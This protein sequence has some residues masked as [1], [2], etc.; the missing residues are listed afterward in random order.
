MIVGEDHDA[1][2]QEE[3]RFVRYFPAQHLNKSTS[4]NTKQTTTCTTSQKLYMYSNKK[5]QNTEFLP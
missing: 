1:T 2:G 5:T 4:A 3:A